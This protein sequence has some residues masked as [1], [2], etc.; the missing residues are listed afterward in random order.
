M[1]ASRRVRSIIY[2]DKE[3]LSLEKK[4]RP[5]NMGRPRTLS[6]GKQSPNQRSATHAG[7]GGL[8]WVEKDRYDKALGDCHPRVFQ[9]T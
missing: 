5:E 1:K 7:F 2:A 9:K 6:V 4:I 8:S 3:A